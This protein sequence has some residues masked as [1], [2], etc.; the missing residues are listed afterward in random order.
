V[1]KAV[2]ADYMAQTAPCNLLAVGSVFASTFYGTT[3]KAIDL[4]IY[5]Y[6]YLAI[7]LSIYL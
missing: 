7:Y 2:V 5:L 6:L 1:L 3:S 4:Y